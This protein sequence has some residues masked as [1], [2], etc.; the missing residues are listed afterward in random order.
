MKRWPNQGV[1]LVEL[2]VTLA[3]AGILAT[4]AVPAFRE[5]ILNNRRAAQLNA[6]TASLMLARSE[7]V[8]TGANAVVCI[9]DGAALP[10]CDT[11]GTQWEDGWL[12]IV[13][14]D[15][16]GTV[17]RAD[18]DLVLEAPAALAEGSTLRGNANVSRRITYNSR[19]SSGS[20]GTLTHCDPRGA[21]EA[22]GIVISN[23]GRP[24]L[25]SDTEVLA[26]P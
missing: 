11:A 14:S 25:T 5:L 16:D 23:T 2:L 3:L 8:K 9:S 10:D 17:S 20:A 15:K 19:G 1:T 12:V 6:M 22:R 26:C 13:D 18:G 7:A 4:I 21:E 24:R